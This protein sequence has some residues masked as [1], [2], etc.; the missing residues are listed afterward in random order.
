MKKIFISPELK[1]ILKD[2]VDSNPK[3]RTVVA[4]SILEVSETGIDEDYVSK[5]YC[6]YF[7][8]SKESKKFISYVKKEKLAEK[9]VKYNDDLTKKSEVTNEML[10]EF[11]EKFFTRKVARVRAKPGKLIS[12]IFKK[13]YIEDNIRARDIEFF[14][15]QYTA[16]VRDKVDFRLVKGEDIKKYYLN[17]NYENDGPSGSL[18]GS[19]MGP[20]ERQP[21]MDFYVNN[22]NVSMLV[23]FSENNKVIA[24]AI[25]WDDVKFYKDGVLFDEGSLMD[26]IY[27]TYDWLESKFKRWAKDEGCYTKTRQAHDALDEFLAPDGNVHRLKVEVPLN[28][29]FEYYPYMDTIPHPNYTKGVLSNQRVNDQFKQL[30]AH[31]S[32][33]PS[34][35]FDF[36]EGKIINSNNAKWSKHSKSYVH[37]DDSIEVES[38]YF[39]KKI[40][41]KDRIGGFIT[42]ADERVKCAYTGDEFAKREMV[43]SEYH[44]GLIHKK[45]SVKSVDAGLIHKDDSVKSNYL[46]KTLSKKGSVKLDKVDDYLPKEI[47]DSGVDIEQLEKVIESLK[48]I[49]GDKDTEDDSST[50]IFEF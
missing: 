28:L 11:N 4:Q 20:K 14:I 19:C 7:T 33:K 30:R 10:Q 25:I 17:E 8:L 21:F 22:D 50:F 13:S 26:R 18:R 16:V 29:Q 32:G 1:T 31:S 37:L 45:E 5:E 35:V 3:E 9:I 42:P 15:N 47:L 24:R 23:A 41:E 43:E 27:Y 34:T 36:L 39:H 44:D 46:G 6:N 48:K 38:E 40:C 2:I 49:Q 12:R